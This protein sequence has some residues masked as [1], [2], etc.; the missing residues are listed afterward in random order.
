MIKSSRGEKIFSIVNL[1]ILTLIAVIVLVP[2]L[3]VLKTSFDVGVKDDLSLSLIPRKF[4]LVF[5]IMIF[6]DKAIIR[7]FLNSAFITIVGTALSVFFNAM[8]AY[9][10]AKRN[11]PGN[12]FLVY[13]LIILPMLFS[14]GLVPTY[15][16]MKSLGLID[17]IVVLII[18]ALISGWSMALIRNYY[19]TIPSSLPESARIDGAKEM[20]VFIKIILPLSKPVLAAIALFTGVGFWNTFFS[21]IMYINSP[22]KYTFP[23]KLRE[24]IIVQYDMRGQFAEAVK[25]ATGQNLLLANLSQEGLSAAIIVVSLLPIILVYP[26]LQRYFTKGLMINSIKG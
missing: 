25:I 26:Y 10:L 9:T 16:M 7:P 5:Y 12:K 2:V 3:Y 21:A 1:A 11:L 14:G 24:M 18:P 13:Y 15:L 8:G 23:V 19:W 22:E 6:K 4:S 17:K 20:T